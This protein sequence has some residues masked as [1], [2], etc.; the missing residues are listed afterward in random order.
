M[1]HPLSGTATLCWR[2]TGSDGDVALVRL[3][4]ADTLSL[5]RLD[6]FDGQTRGRQRADPAPA[7]V[8]SPEE[9]S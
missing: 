5:A 2:T 6:G 4:G 7:L 1:A 9:P 8:L 3:D